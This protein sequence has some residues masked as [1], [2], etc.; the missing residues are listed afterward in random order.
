MTPRNTEREREATDTAIGSL[1]SLSFGEGGIAEHIQ[2]FQNKKRNTSMWP[3]PPSCKNTNSQC[4]WPSRQ[5]IQ[6]FTSC[7]GGHP[8]KVGVMRECKDPIAVSVASL[9]LSLSLYSWGSP[10]I[11]HIKTSHPHFPIFRIFA[12]FLRFPRSCSS[13][14]FLSVV[15]GTFHIFRIFH[16]SGSNR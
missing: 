16:L 4:K 9:S 6:D 7:H 3:V 11:S 5:R 2:P 13:D 15:R 10:E 14:P 12:H 1:H 8:L